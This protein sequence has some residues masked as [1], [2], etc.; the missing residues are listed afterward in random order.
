MKRTGESRGWESAVGW[1][2]LVKK[3]VKP[4][5][6]VR[7]D[8]QSGSKGNGIGQGGGQ[9]VGCQ[10]KGSGLLCLHLPAWILTSLNPGLALFALGHH[11]K[12]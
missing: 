2:R 1:T 8:K 3:Q 12:L 5:K 9:G 6:P 11:P 10:P 7:E 4:V